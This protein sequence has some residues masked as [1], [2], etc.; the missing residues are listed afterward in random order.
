MRGL[1]RYSRELKFEGKIND[2]VDTGL[3]KNLVYISQAHVH[4]KTS[5]PFFH[6]MKGRE[7]KD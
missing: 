2:E 5:N 1:K 4:P 6:A 7:R 3:W